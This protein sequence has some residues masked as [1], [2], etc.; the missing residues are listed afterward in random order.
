MN[1]PGYAVVFTLIGSYKKYGE[2]RGS[3]Q[4]LDSGKVQYLS[5]YYLR[6]MWKI[7]MYNTVICNIILIMYSDMYKLFIVI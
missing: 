2:G 5:R 6:G 4:K 7:K 1:L 3:P